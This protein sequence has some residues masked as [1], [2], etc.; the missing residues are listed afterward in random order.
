MLE[1]ASRRRNTFNPRADH[2]LS[3]LGVPEISLG[4][5]PIAVIDRAHSARLLVGAAKRHQAE[6]LDPLY[7]T[8]AN[9]EVVSLARRPAIRALFLAADLIH[10]DG[11]PLV[12]ASRLRSRLALP[13]RCATTDLFH[14][15]ARVAQA[16]G[17]SFYFLGATRESN[18]R[19][20]AQARRLYPNLIV[21]GANHG[22]FGE[23][24]EPAVVARINAARPG[25][26]W[27]AMGVP[28]EQLFATRNLHRLK[29][30]GV[31][32]TSGGLFDFLSG[33]RS[34]APRW[35]QAA[36]LEWSYRLMIEP[37]RLFPRYLKTNPHALMI[38]L[39][40]ALQ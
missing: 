25:I 3:R 32:K 4:G 24:E 22:Y 30:V 31:I 1:I 2:Y 34:R 7:V 12:W 26:L 20:V 21:A 9:G 29:G 27:V 36:G 17:V 6:G 8:S 5:L 19:A 38:L 33:A 16:E 39:A 10:A 18:E 35:M 23:D 13:E 28:R 40:G 15:T 11:Q 37:R 14:D